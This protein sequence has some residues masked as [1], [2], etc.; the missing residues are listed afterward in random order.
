M[1]RLKLSERFMCYCEILTASGADF[2]DLK[3]IIDL[4]KAE[5]QGLVLKLP[6][7]VGD[8][9]YEVSYIYE[10]KHD[11]ACPEFEPFK[12]EEEIPCEHEYKKYSVRERDFCISCL[13]L[14]NRTVFLTKAEAE[15]ALEEMECE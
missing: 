12:C 4:L 9:V 3:H 6:C 5:E 11:Y 8:T 10:C 14:L 1:E 15:K 13:A 7:K 2:D